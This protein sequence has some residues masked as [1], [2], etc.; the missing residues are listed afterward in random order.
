M[1]LPGGPNWSGEISLY[2]F[3]IEDPITFRSSI[4]VTL[5]H[6]HANKRNDDWSSVAYWYQ[7]LPG[8]PLTL[9]PVSARL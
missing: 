9:L 3:H 1:T 7:T 8:K 2:R 6:G 5:E 4:K